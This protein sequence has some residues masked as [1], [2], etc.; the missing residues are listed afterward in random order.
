QR[1]AE[2]FA[3]TIVGAILLYGRG[4]RQNNSMPRGAPLKFRTA[5]FAR[6]GGC[7][8]GRRNR[9]RARHRIREAP[10]LAP[11]FFMVLSEA[12]SGGMVLLTCPRQSPFRPP[13]SQCRG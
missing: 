6:S 7:P 4:Y 5:L 1:R 11:L 3:S 9:I 13:A 10:E 12:C 2:L 8:L